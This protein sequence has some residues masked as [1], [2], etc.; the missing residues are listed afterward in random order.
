MLTQHLQ[1]TNVSVPGMTHPSTR[2][3]SHQQQH[4]TADHETSSDAQRAQDMMSTVSQPEP[5][6]KDP[7]VQLELM[8]IVQQSL[9]LQ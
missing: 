1:A 5:L 8:L 6:T 4:N 3:P 9:M 2:D 7:C